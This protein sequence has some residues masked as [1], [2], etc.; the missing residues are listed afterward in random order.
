M[1]MNNTR[2]KLAGLLAG[3]GLIL[4]ACAAPLPACEKADD[5]STRMA[6]NVFIVLGSFLG[7][8]FLE[9]RLL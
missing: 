3:L 1:T 5:D 7:G 6:K 2:F 9:D 4:G 8:H